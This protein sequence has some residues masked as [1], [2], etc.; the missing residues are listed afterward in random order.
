MLRYP[1]YMIERRKNYPVYPPNQGSSDIFLNMIAWWNFDESSGDAIDSHDD[2]DLGLVGTTGYYATGSPVASP[3][4]SG[5]L[6]GHFFRARTDA[7]FDLAGG[8]FSFFG[9]VQFE[10]TNDA[11]NFMFFQFGG[12]IQPWGMNGR[13]GDVEQ[14]A[15][16]TSTTTYQQAEVLLNTVGST[17]NFICVTYDSATGELRTYNLTNG[18]EAAPVI[19]LSAGM[20]N[21]ASYNDVWALGYPPR[22]EHE[23]YGWRHCLT[24]YKLTEA[25]MIYLYNNGSGRSY[26]EVSGL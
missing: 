15:Y 7:R 11:F 8:D 10:A 21:N 25:D 24:R 6:T 23:V 20:A 12:G 5:N 17:W 14:T 16:D 19:D 22:Y 18:L 9:W 2:L 26:A 13:N 4:R 1:Q 3:C